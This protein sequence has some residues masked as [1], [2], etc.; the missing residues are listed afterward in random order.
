MTQAHYV[1]ETF[2]ENRLDAPPKPIVGANH[3]R[4]WPRFKTNDTY[5]SVSLIY[6]GVG[7]KKRLK[8]EE[9]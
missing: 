5:H 3:D 1:A 6:L 2:I 7:L 8:T 4:K 9:L